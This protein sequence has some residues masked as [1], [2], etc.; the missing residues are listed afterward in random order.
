[1]IE[2]VP[3][4]YPKRLF[5][6]AREDEMTKE[7]KLDEIFENHYEKYPSAADLERGI[8]RAILNWSQE[9]DPGM[10]ERIWAAL[11]EIPYREE[12]IELI[13]QAVRGTSKEWCSHTFYEHG[14]WVCQVEQDRRLIIP[15]YWNMCAIC[16]A[17]RPE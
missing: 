3:R 12:A 10:E 15:E 14:N 13:L 9:P 17:K 7:Q 16:G 4:T 5:N 8:K 11:G 6:V 2:H 1:M